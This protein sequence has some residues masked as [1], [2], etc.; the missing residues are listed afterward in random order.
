ML[1]L[2]RRSKTTLFHSCGFAVGAVGWSGHFWAPGLLPLLPLLL[3]YASE[4][5][6]ARQNS[7]AVILAYHAGAT[8]TRVLGAPWFLGIAFR[9]VD[10]AYLCGAVALS[11][12]VLWVI[13]RAFRTQRVHW[14]VPLGIPLALAAASLLPTGV[15]N[16]L[17]AAEAFF[18]ESGWLGVA[19]M[20][21]WFGAIA[22]SPR[23]ALI[24]GLTAA[25]LCN[26][27]PCGPSNP[28]K[29][30]TSTGSD[31]GRQYQ[32][33]GKRLSPCTTTSFA[34]EQGEYST[35]RSTNEPL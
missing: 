14:G 33:L 15:V 23:K 5:S 12:S 31:G 18:P 17:A 32:T 21:A 29:P 2:S 16:P 8:W 25:V 35:I 30:P 19:L 1:N 28:S 20:V 9:P 34:L 11:L 26:L 24:V 3:Y 7:F 27:G 4:S 10:I 22:V 6:A 13:F